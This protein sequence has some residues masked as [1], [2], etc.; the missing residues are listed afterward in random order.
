MHPEQGY[1]EKS[2][3]RDD[4]PEIADLPGSEQFEIVSGAPPRRRR[5]DE[6]DGEVE[7]GLDIV[8]PD[9]KEKRPVLP[10]DKIQEIIDSIDDE[11][12]EMPPKPTIH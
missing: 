10:P 2:P 6:D 4:E 5:Q 12:Q 3:D 1:F 9:S 7:P 8:P 11:E